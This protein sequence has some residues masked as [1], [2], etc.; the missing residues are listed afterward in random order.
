MPQV[1]D[2]FKLFGTIE[3]AGQ[4]SEADLARIF[5]IKWSTSDE[6]NRPHFIVYEAR[7]D[8]GPYKSLLSRAEARIPDTEGIVRVLNLDFRD[9]VSLSRQA[10]EAKY[11]L[12]EFELAS[13]TAPPEV[14]NMLRVRR[15]W[16]SIV[17][18]LSRDGLDQVRSVSFHV[19][20]DVD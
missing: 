17:F 3:R 5:E 20:V 14:P 1:D 7:V 4:F 6:S 13:A 2:L 15:S 18:G 19:D 10:I 12:V 16:G 11:K 9:G 8:Q